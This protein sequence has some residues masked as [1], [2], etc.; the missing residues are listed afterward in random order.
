MYVILTINFKTTYGTNQLQRNVNIFTF[1]GFFS[2]RQFWWFDTFI[3]DMAVM[4]HF[5]DLT[6]SLM[7]DWNFDKVKTCDQNWI[8]TLHT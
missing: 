2:P 8:Q 3:N 1:F 7:G 5:S 6:L 4:W